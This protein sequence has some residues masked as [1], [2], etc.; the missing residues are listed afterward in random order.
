MKPD[1]LRGLLTAVRGCIE[2]CMEHGDPLSVL[3][4]AA[5]DQ[6]NELW[7]AAQLEPEPQFEIIYVLAWLHW[8]RYLALPEGLDR[9]DRAAA[10]KFLK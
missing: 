6:A 2:N 4:P 7:L 8:C 5:L 3:E 1:H 9:E 10:L